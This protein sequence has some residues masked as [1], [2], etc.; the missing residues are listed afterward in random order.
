MVHVRPP[1]PPTPPSSPFGGGVSRG[2]GGRLNLLLT[3]GGWAACG[4]GD[5]WANQLPTLLRPL[6]V[7]VLTAGSGHEA[8]SVIRDTPVHIAVVDLALPM[9]ASDNPNESREAGLRILELLARLEE[10]PPTVVI[11]RRCTPREGSRGLASAL[12]AGAFAVVDRPVQLETVLDI[13]R[14]V[15][16]RHYSGRWPTGAQP[17][18]D[19]N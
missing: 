1:Q 5:V 10:P 9:G 17:G 3:C 13:M 18:G 19:L 15:V 16:R 12:A 14:R 2:E 11:R 8:T 4:G 6:G 7:E